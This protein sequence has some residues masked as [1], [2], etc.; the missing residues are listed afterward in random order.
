[1]NDA[2]TRLDESHSLFLIR[3]EEPHENKLRIVVQ[4]SELHPELARDI[5]FGEVNL[6][7]GTPILPTGPIFEISWPKNQYIAYQVLNESYGRADDS[8]FTGNHLRIYARSPFLDFLQATSIAPQAFPRSIFALPDLLRKPCHRHCIA[9]ESRSENLGRR[10]RIGA[11]FDQLATAPTPPTNPPAEHE[12]QSRQSAAYPHR[13]P[14]IRQ[15]RRHK[16][17]ALQ[18]QSPRCHERPS[19]QNPATARELLRAGLPAT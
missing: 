19:Q 14:R 11:L 1:M 10:R 15:P 12:S 8:E 7:P 13:I 4:A 3:I 17:A 9:R 6:G 2:W 5:V 16:P 18:D